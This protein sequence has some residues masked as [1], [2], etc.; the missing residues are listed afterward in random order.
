MYLN[1][2]AEASKHALD[3]NN[4]IF[5]IETEQHITVEIVVE[6]FYTTSANGE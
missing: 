6:R 5:F 1:I 3:S 2:L 4:S